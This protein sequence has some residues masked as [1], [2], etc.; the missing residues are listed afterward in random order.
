M[1]IQAPW[2][3][4]AMITTTSTT[5]VAAAPTAL[6]TT[7]RRQPFSRERRQWSTMLLWL[8]VK[9]VNTPTTYSWIRR[10]TCAPK[11]TINRAA[12]SET[13]RMP[14][15]KTRRSPRLRNWRGMRR[16]PARMAER[17]GKSW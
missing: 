5:P 15:E 10:L 4:L 7:E 2:V 12:S 13:T 16:W 8:R 11:A 1:T 17:R 9:E 6:N 14:L 3:N